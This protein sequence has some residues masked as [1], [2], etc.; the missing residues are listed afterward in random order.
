MVTLSS[1]QYEQ[2]EKALESAVIDIGQEYCYAHLRK[3]SA[4]AEDNIEC[5]SQDVLGALRVLR[6]AKCST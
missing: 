4:C 3:G 2:I 6:E 5:S 1:E